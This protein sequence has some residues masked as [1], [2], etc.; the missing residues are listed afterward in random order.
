MLLLLDPGSLEHNIHTEQ[1]I[2]ADARLLRLHHFH[3][4]HGDQVR[5]DIT[6]VN[7]ARSRV[8]VSSTGYR[9]DLTDPL[10]EALVD[11]KDLTKDHMY[12]VGI[13]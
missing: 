11:G 10:L 13:S 4:H 12:T 7:R 9:V 5:T 2:D 8:T 6:A 1:A 3:L